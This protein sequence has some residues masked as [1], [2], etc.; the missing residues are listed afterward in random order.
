MWQKVWPQE[1]AYGT[2]KVRV[3]QTPNI[4]LSY[5]RLRVQSEIE[6]APKATLD[7]HTQALAR[8]LKFYLN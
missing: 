1:V 8:P 6:E 7:F 2:L 3:W 5:R 4:Q